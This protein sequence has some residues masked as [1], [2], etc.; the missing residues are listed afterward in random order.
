M[1]SNFNTPVATAVRPMMIGRNIC[2]N[3]SRIGASII[4][5]R[6]GPVRAR[7]FG[8]ISPSSMCR[9]DT[10]VSAI[11]SASGWTSSYGT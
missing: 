11:T 2:T 3:S 1:R 6:S 7:F 9:Q 5:A 10:N 4:A 8:T